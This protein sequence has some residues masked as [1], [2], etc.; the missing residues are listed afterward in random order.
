MWI[1]LSAYGSISYNLLTLINSWRIRQALSPHRDAA[2]ASTFQ[3]LN[4]CTDPIIDKTSPEKEKPFFIL[5]PI[6]NGKIFVFYACDKCPIKQQVC[7]NSH[8]FIK[9]S[10][11]FQEK[12]SLRWKI[13]WHRNIQIIK[14]SIV[15]RYRNSGH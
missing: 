6:K 4:D 11:L 9:W 7:D 8:T 12:F 10:W 14:A 13:T 3:W 5:F 15:F 2:A 1:G